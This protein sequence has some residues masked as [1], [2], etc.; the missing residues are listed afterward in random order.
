MKQFQCC[1]LLFRARWMISNWMY[2]KSRQ[3]SSGKGSH[4]WKIFK[5]YQRVISLR[6]S[7]HA[8]EE[9]PNMWVYEDSILYFV[10]FFPLIQNSNQ[11]SIKKICVLGWVGRI[12]LNLC[13]LLTRSWLIV[14][15]GSIR[16]KVLCFYKVDHSADQ[17]RSRG[18]SLTSVTLATAATST[19][20]MKTT[21]TLQANLWTVNKT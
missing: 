1:K 4:R 6:P 3:N 16:P 12:C 11:H 17:Q 19:H 10:L 18:L 21:I 9:N 13:V 15:M 7:C 20:A 8:T 5:G 2:G 14:W